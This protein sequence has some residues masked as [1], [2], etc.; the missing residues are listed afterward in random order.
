[1]DTADGTRGNSLGGADAVDRA[2]AERTYA[3]YLSFKREEPKFWV[4]AMRPW[5]DTDVDQL[6]DIRVR[7]SDGRVNFNDFC[8][9]ASRGKRPIKGWTRWFLTDKWRLCVEVVTTS[10]NDNRGTWGILPSCRNL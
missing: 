7:K 9:A 5:D 10:E 3:D 1:M 6:R 4:F 8:T 2:W